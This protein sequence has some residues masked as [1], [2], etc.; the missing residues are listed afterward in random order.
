MYRKFLIILIFHI[1]NENSVTAKRPFS[2]VL[3]SNSFKYVSNEMNQCSCSFQKLTKSRYAISAMAN[4]LRDLSK[5]AEVGILIHITYPKKSKIFKFLDIKLN[6]CDSLKN[7]K[8]MT[9]IKE[10]FKELMASS[11]LPFACPIKGNVTYN[12]TDFMLTDEIFPTY[13]PIV[14]F[15]YTFSIYSNQKLLTSYELLG[16]TVPRQ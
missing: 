4:F 6:I 9:L 15:N 11:N 7:L 16:S 10:L 14:H 13:T 1:L 12:I 3:H 8:A 2:L 5:N